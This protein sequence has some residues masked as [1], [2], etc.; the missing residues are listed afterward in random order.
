MTGSSSGGRPGR[1]VRIELAT[2]EIEGS[3]C[4]GWADPSQVMAVVAISEPQD[5]FARYLEP[6]LAEDP[7][8]G[9]R[10]DAYSAADAEAGEGRLPPALRGLIRR[11][12][13][14]HRR[15]YR[16][17]KSLMRDPRW[18]SLTCAF[19]EEERIY[20]VKGA[21]SRVY[22][23]R[24]GKAYRAEEEASASEGTVGA[25][26]KHENL[27]L[28]V[29][30]LPV[31]AGDTVVLLTSES[32][33]PPD[34]RA[35]TNV[36]SQTQDLK[37][38]CDGLV[39]LLGLQA[40]GASAVA[41][42]FLAI[43]AESMG[44]ENPLEGL[45]EELHVGLEARG[46]DTGIPERDP[47]GVRSG[48]DFAFK[49][50]L[51]DGIP[52]EARVAGPERE[53]LDLAECCAAC[54][55]DA[56]ST[57]ESGVCAAGGTPSGPV[58][59]APRRREAGVFWPV[60]VALL[61]AGLALLAAIPIREGTPPLGSRFIN[62][63]QEQDLRSLIPERGRQQESHD[64]AVRRGAGFGSLHVNPDPPA[65]SVLLN[66]EV[67][68]SGTPVRIDRIPVGRHRVGLDLGPCGIWET[69]CFIARD[70]T[71]TFAPRLVGSVEIV[72]S[73]P[74]LG[75]LAWAPGRSKT[76]VPARIDSLPVGWNRVF[77]EDERLPMWDRNILVRAGETARI[78]VPNDFSSD[79]G[80]VRVASMA[81][82]PGE[83]LV[84][85]AGDSV[86]VDGV[87]AGLT[88]FERS[89]A[90][91]LHS[92]RI[93]DGHGGHY[94]EILEVRAGST[95]HV[96]GRLESSPRPAIHHNA[97]EKVWI[98]GPVL[99]SV[100]IRGASGS[101]RPTLHLPE[102]PP[103]SRQIPMTPVDESRGVYVGVVSP[104][105]LPDG[106][107]VPYYF[108][109]RGSNGETVW[110]DLYRLECVEEVASG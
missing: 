5:A 17:N 83:G 54:D 34:L 70:Q 57:E 18:V 81:F 9:D 89:L 52:E 53:V 77:Y 51:E 37:R 27:K 85:S 87:F 10:E 73:D 82:R 30:S 88:P 90:P 56:E 58:P 69:E 48:R 67:R 59:A 99:L 11:L 109:I 32:D 29:T 64:G 105:M 13:A 100:E 80:L 92:V 4:R 86:W 20:F 110:S 60:L 43:G 44:R 79:Q 55:P 97:P 107:S 6:L 49:G 74:G 47:A 46:I 62:W 101:V 95:R 22:L 15:L 33:T 28:E 26:G 98:R 24:G 72:A 8:A 103:G 14:V 45:A 38:A 21:P 1:P 36:F 35:L 39:N 76:P 41:L 50:S 3:R 61:V 93:G 108:T 42:R 84:E 71:A 23:L 91:G 104:E 2:S 63:L 106:R 78:I 96:Q 68:A 31:L 12:K 66:G 7:D 19:A 102:L 16:E 65:R 75:G 94:S 25:L 40:E